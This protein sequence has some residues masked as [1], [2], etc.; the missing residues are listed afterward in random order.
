MPLERKREGEVK[1]GGRDERKGG[2]RTGTN[3]FLLPA[4]HTSQKE[5]QD[6]G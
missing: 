2:G 6:L 5:Y 3:R 1:G 4:K